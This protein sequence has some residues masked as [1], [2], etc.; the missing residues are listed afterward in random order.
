MDVLGHFTHDSLEQWFLS[1]QTWEPS[2]GRPEARGDI[3][4]IIKK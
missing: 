3:L 2:E 1:L 4:S